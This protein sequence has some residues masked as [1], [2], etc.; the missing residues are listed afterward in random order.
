MIKIDNE[1]DNLICIQIP[2]SERKNFINE[3]KKMLENNVNIVINSNTSI[4]K[5]LL[6]LKDFIIEVK[7][8]EINI[9][10]RR[11]DCIELIEAIEE[12]IEENS[13]LPLDHSF[14]SLGAVIIPETFEDV[15]IETID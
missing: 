4:I 6:S 1:T 7:D 14:E 9:S 5:I 12:H 3:L 13:D 15:V 10:L 8:N 11:E 2:L